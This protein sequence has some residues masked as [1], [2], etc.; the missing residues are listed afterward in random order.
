MDFEFGE[1]GSGFYPDFPELFDAL[2]HLKS[3]LGILKD[4]LIHKCCALWKL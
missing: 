4:L 2:L 3:P 1:I